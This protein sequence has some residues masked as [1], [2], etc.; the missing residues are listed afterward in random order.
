MFQ[1]RKNFTKWKIKD[2]IIVSKGKATQI[3]Q[4]QFLYI[5]LQFS[6]ISPKKQKKKFLLRQKEGVFV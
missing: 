5:P 1:G 2:I 4:M 6:R 3:S